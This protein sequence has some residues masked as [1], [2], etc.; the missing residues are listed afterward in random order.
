MRSEYISIKSSNTSW[1]MHEKGVG[2]HKRQVFVK[3]NMQKSCNLVEPPVKISKSGS[4][5]DEGIDPVCLI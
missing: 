2:D 1:S 4:D 5:I 3:C